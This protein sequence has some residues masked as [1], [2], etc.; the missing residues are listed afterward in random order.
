MQPRT[1]IQLLALKLS[2]EATQ[3]DL[4]ELE[5]LMA[6]HPEAVYHE[7][8]L[9]Q[10][11]HNKTE[12]LDTDYHYNQHRLKYQDKLIF[13]EQ[14]VKAFNHFKPT[15]RFYAVCSL[16]LIIA[17]AGLFAYHFKNLT[18]GTQYNTRI[19]SGQRVHKNLLLPDGT[20]VCLNS[21]SKL[22]YD[23]DMI[24]R[25]TRSVRLTGE[26]FF[27]VAH[28]KAH[29]FIIRTD[30][31]SV[32]VL[33]TAFNVKA[34]PTD[35]KTETTLLRGSIELSLNNGNAEKVI[36]KPSEKFALIDNKL[37]ASGFTNITPGKTGITMMIQNISPVKVAGKEYTE[38]VSWVNNEL[39]FN[40]ETFEEL[41]PK[42][43][44]WYN[45]KL[46]IQR[47]EINDYH[48]T[49]VFTHE[50]LTEALTAMKLIKSFNFKIKDHDVTIY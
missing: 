31:I 38:E 18:A 8:L 36:L 47:E 50:N 34:Y 32:K 43:E 17:M 21:D 48:F 35:H 33:G 39:V 26:A 1:V 5:E 25:S 7:E 41:V 37:K 15:T 27:E 49:G 10:L 30:K 23:K 14:T 28:D 46:E 2:G 22:E 42:L 9:K 4:A 40:N 3:K 24:K 44:R 20:K 45:I 6:K 11:F 16:V 29:P 19:I 13:A 12:D